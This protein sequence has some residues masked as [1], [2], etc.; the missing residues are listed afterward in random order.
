MAQSS[1]DKSISAGIAD[2][3]I[4]AHDGD[5]A[6]LYIYVTRTGCRD[7]EKAAHDL[8]RTLREVEAAAEKLERMELFDTAPRKAAEKTPLPPPEDTL[9]EYTSDEIVRRTKDD[10]KFACLVDE[11]ARVLGHVL[12]GGDLRQLFGLYDHLG[13]PA[14]VIMELMNFCG[15]IAQSK[16]KNGALLRTSMRRIVTEGYNWA[17]NEILTLE[18][19][20]EYIRRH[21]QRVSGIEALRSLLG[22]AD[23]RMT[24]TDE[25]YLSSWLEMGFGE[26][27]VN[28][29]YERTVAQTGSLKWQYMDTILRSWNGK[30]LHSVSAIEL[31][32]PLRSAGSTPKA[33]K[34]ADPAVDYGQLSKAIDKI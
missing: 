31:K 15:D 16:S 30:G 5:V 20:E 25:T 24:K 13:M 4:A 22:I 34:K 28:L 7:A 23:R 9:P 32:D 11:A 8:C 19:A 17:N 6:L 12:G 26:A 18:Q 27:E 10:G 21:K 29:A 2:K 1:I 14:E 3:L 33:A